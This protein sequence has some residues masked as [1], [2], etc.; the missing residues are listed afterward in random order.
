MK[1]NIKKYSQIIILLLITTKAS[2]QN[3]E[4]IRISNIN[5]TTPINT[6]KELSFISNK[7]R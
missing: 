1:L 6:E 3:E 5:K 7:L 2:A 4:R